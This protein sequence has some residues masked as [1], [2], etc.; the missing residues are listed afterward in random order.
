MY[1]QESDK[2]EVEDQSRSSLTFCGSRT[3]ERGEAAA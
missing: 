1:W 3:E 2:T